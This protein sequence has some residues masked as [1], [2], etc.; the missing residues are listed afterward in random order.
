MKNDKYATV[1]HWG[2]IAGED[3]SEFEEEFE[4][5]Q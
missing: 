3:V 2:I 4:D 1:R 5:V